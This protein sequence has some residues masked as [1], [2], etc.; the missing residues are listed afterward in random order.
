MV[1]NKKG[2]NKHK[3][4]G[5]T[6]KVVMKNKLVESKNDQ[7]LYGCVTKLFTWNGRSIMQ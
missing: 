6:Y 1:K 7:E 2:G 4:G 5:K 3:N